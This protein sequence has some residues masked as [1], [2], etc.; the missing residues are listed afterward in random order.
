LILYNDYK[1]KEGAAMIVVKLIGGL[2]NQ[3]F[4]YAFGRNVSLK[5]NVPLLLDLSGLLDRSYKKNFTYRNYNLDIFSMQPRF[6]NDLNSIYIEES[7]YKKILKN[8]CFP[9][10]SFRVVKEKKISFSNKYLNCS[11][12][13]YFIG[14]WQSEKYFHDI[15]DV[16]RNDFII[17][18]EVDKNLAQKI[19]DTESVCIHVRRG[20]FVNNPVANM[21]HG[22]CDKQYYYNAMDNIRQ[23]IDAPNIFI[24]SDDI[25]WCQEN[26]QFDDPTTFISHDLAEKKFDQDLKLMSLCKNFVISNSSFG[27]WGA[28]LSKYPNKIVIAPIR[29]LNDP[30]ID[31]RDLIPETWMRI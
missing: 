20:D 27:W 11:K 31:T 2:G 1:N 24:F 9:Y 4:Q 29:W 12:N 30:S 21:Y 17:R 22:V 28:W 26:L 6:L 16:I 19:S 7:R 23:K 13:C 18:S 8:I 15:Q 14:Y 3:M 10:L 25:T 5:H